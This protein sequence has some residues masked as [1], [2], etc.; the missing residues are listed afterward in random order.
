MAKKSITICKKITLK[1]AKICGKIFSSMLD[2]CVAGCLPAAE[3]SFNMNEITIMYL[4]KL[5]WRRIWALI[6]AMVIFAGA[7][8]AYCELLATPKYTATASVLVTN[9]SI[10]TTNSIQ[11]GV[12]AES[13]SVKTTDI[14][15]SLYLAD[16]II[17]ILTTSDIF[18]QLSTSMGDKYTYDQ[19]RS[20]ATVSRKGDDTLFVNV[21]FSASTADEAIMLANA[22]VKLAPD[23]ITKYIPYSNA[24]VAATADS[25]AEVYPRTLITTAVA[26]MLGAVLA[27]AG[28]FIIDSMDHALNGEEDFVSRY[29]IPLLGSVPDF[30]NTVMN[31]SGNYNYKKGGY[32]SGT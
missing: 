17:D 28:V 29:D 23:Y 10:T 9:G 12:E 32:R 19:L 13:N 30:E 21:S 27:F 8:F 31:S 14:S 11:N 4:L 24:M 6:L 26:G 18:K 25:A 15:A 5:A 1:K 3:R 2:N 7:A 20:M 16:T 22:F